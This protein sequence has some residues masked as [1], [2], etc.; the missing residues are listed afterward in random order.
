MEVKESQDE[1]IVTM[2]FEQSNSWRCIETV[3]VSDYL[4]NQTKFILFEKTTKFRF[5][6]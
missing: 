2:K 1:F 5:D 6:K 3:T 4:K